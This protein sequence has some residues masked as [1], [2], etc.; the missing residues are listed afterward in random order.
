MSR[1]YR[2]PSHTFACGSHPKEGKQVTSRTL[3]RKSRQLLHIEE[4]DF[5]FAHIQDSNRGKSGSKDLDW[6]AVY[7]GDGS[8]NP[9]QAELDAKD[10]EDQTW[11][12]SLKRK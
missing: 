10:D 12:E 7:F 4:E 9:Y 3:R 8:T 1:S 5:D 11:F 2:K 6:G